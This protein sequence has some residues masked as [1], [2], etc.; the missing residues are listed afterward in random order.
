[1]RLGTLRS[2]VL[3]TC[4]IPVAAPIASAAPQTYIRISSPVDGFQEITNTNT[5]TTF[6]GVVVDAFA[7]FNANGIS[8]TGAESG[9]TSGWRD[10]WTVT[11]STGTGSLTIQWRLTGTLVVGAPPAI[12]T[13]CVADS[14]AVTLRSL[15][16]SSSIF[17]AGSSIIAVSQNVPGTQQVQVTGS[18][19]VPF[20]YDTP[21]GAGLRLDGG[22]GDD[23][24]GGGVSFPDGAEITAVTLPV[25]ATL[26][27]ASG[28]SYPVLQT[29]A[30]LLTNLAAVNAG[31]SQGEHLLLNALAG[32]NA[33]HVVAACGQLNAFVNMVEAQAGKDLTATDA[34][35][36][37][38]SASVAADAMGCR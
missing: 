7:D 15:F 20:T 32:F 6:N 2:V 4:L 29:P 9:A 30:S 25:G 24:Y 18:F 27:A 11:G 22:T 26:I 19:V 35:A 33:G 34:D 38:L 14:A 31:V 36:L 5:S 17:S 16:G 21:F 10:E 1:M 28:R 23:F 12:C 37:I 13:T 8:I 3:V